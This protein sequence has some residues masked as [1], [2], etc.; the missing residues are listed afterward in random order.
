MPN[1]DIVYI[2]GKGQAVERPIKIFYD[3]LLC[4]GVKVNNHKQLMELWEK[5]KR[6]FLSKVGT[7]Q[8]LLI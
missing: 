4:V 3:M 1:Y 8:G 5:Q 6:Q 2:N 7:Q